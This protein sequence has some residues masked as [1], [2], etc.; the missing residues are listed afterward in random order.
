MRSL[1][2]NYIELYGLVVLQAS[3]CQSPI[4]SDQ[5]LLESPQL[6][7]VMCDIKFTDSKIVGVT[8]NF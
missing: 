4:L 8:W 3:R 5:V 6:L 2:L 7:G 1:H